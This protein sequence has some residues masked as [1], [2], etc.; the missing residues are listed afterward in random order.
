MK[1]SVTL[2]GCFI[3]GVVLSF[4]AL[5]PQNI[6]AFDFGAISNWLLYVLLFF[7]GI[8]I[9]MDESIL[10]IIKD[11]PRRAMI[12]PLLT[13]IGSIAATVVVFY[14]L[15]WTGFL[16]GNGVALKNVVA[17]NSALGYYSLS[18]ILLTEAWGAQIGSIALLSNLLRELLTILFGPLIAKYFG[19]YSL[20]ACG[21][22][23]VTDTTMPII[24]K[25]C[26]NSSFAL[27]MYSGIV[28]NIVIPFILAFLVSI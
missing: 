23:T 25:S 13:V 8:S 5:L 6:L 12:A 28:L 9:G 21:G 16:Q 10:Q 1:V 14:I 26:G 7:V 19:P 22:V 20:V 11:M 24:L 17:A 4:F 2:L 18:G 15:R 3:A 27:T